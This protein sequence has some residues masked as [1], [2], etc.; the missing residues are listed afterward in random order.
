MG[1]VSLFTELYGSG[2]DFSSLTQG[3]DIVKIL[4]QFNPETR[5]VFVV[6]FLSVISSWYFTYLCYKEIAYITNEPFF[7]YCFW[8]Y[9]IGSLSIFILVGFAILAIVAA[10][11]VMA[12]IKAQEL[13]TSYSAKG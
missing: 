6:G 9:F 10:L 11:W 12:W 7:R 3:A 8:C 5:F 1:G 13:R 4:G 2:W